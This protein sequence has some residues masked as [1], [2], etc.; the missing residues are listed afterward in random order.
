MK[1]IFLFACV[2]S[3]LMASAQMKEGKVVYER[4]LQMRMRVSNP[5]LAERI[6]QSRTDQFELLFA[7]NQSL[8]QYLPQADENDGTVSANGMVFRMAGNNNDIVFT[9][10]TDRKRVDQRELFDRQ[11]LVEDSLRSLS[12][13][14]SDETKSILGYTARKATA[15]RIGVRSQ[16]TMENGEMKRQELPDT[17]VITAWFT[18]DIP[19]AV[20]PQEFQG[21]LPGLILEL[22]QNKG[23]IVYKAVEVSPKVKVA[24][25]KEPKKGKRMSQEAFAKERDQLMQ[26]MQKNMP[27]GRSIR[28]SSFN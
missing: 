21:Q 15:E 6:P 11:Y 23:R 18:T 8:W 13:K 26:E 24:D 28:I 17:S 22:D 2:A 9:S 3:S 12:W 19:V 1:K 4:T 10:L 16:M 14:L 5:E 27:A 20:G 25:I 7:N